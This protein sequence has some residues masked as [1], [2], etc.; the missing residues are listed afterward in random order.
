MTEPVQRPKRPRVLIIALVLLPL[1]AL[2]F[3]MTAQN[4]AG[5]SGRSSGLHSIA[6]VFCLLAIWFNWA[7]ITSV[8]LLA[9]LTLQ[10]APGGFVNLGDP[11]VGQA[12]SYAVIGTVFFV[13]GTV[14]VFQTSSNEY[15]RQARRWRKERKSRRHAEI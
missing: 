6:W 8:V 2:L 10:W 11:D 13:A 14:L 15:Y 9:F 7:R 12:A 3:A 1:A 4:L 5:L